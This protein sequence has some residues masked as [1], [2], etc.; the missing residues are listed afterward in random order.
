MKLSSVITVISLPL[1]MLSLAFGCGVV[2]SDSSESSQEGASDSRVV[3]KLETEKFSGEKWDPVECTITENDIDNSED[4]NN[5]LIQKL[6]TH[7]SNED[8][9]T[10][11]Y[12]TT[13]V[14]YK[15]MHV[16]DKMDNGVLLMNN[17]STLQSRGGIDAKGK[18]SSSGLLRTILEHLCE[19]KI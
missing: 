10:G 11:L 7:A 12:I 17:R 1:A 9:V 5:E 16:F 14:P 19:G 2:G 3:M 18:I 8:I 6:I 13:P 4:F 15:V